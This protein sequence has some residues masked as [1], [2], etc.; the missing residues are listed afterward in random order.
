MSDSEAHLIRKG[1]TR[2]RG[3]CARFGVSMLHREG[4]SRGGFGFLPK[5]KPNRNFGSVS[6]FF[7]LNEKK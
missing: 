2:Q 7:F 1:G 5:P 4:E 6:F 3:G